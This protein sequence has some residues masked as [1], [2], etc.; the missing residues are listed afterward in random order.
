MLF[1]SEK[2]DAGAGV[3][4]TL[5][6]ATDVRFGLSDVHV[7]ELGPLDRE[8]VEVAGCGNGFGDQGF[9]CPRRS[10]EQDSYVSLDK[11][12]LNDCMRLPDRFFSPS[13]NN[14][15][16]S[17]GSCIVSK[18]SN[19]TCASPPTSS[20]DTLGILGAP[21]LSE[22]ESLAFPS[23]TSKSTAVS[24]TKSSAPAKELEIQTCEQL[25]SFNKKKKQTHT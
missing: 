24:G 6:H 2:D 19:L 8:K 25:F 23:A 21:M 5:E 15:G 11:F 16:C 14:S 4:R 20:H 1:R 9:P 7:Q 3:A 18:M 22:Y 12:G 17:S 10:I 13:A